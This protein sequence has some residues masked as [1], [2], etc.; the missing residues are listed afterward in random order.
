MGKGEKGK[1]GKGERLL[2]TGTS[3][4]FLLC[5]FSLVERVGGTFQ[6]F[7]VLTF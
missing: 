7:N 3:T 1:R 4:P 2:I 5:S 6:R